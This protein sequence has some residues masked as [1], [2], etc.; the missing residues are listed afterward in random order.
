MNFAIVCKLGERAKWSSWW[1]L[2][3]KESLNSCANSL[4]LA[5]LARLAIGVPNS[6]PDDFAQDTY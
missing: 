1:F 4:G 6:L 2:A 5:G 3:S